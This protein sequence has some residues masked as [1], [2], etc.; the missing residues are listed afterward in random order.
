MKKTFV[1]PLALSLM[2]AG[3]LNMPT[4]PDQITG[5]YV[6]SAKYS[7]FDCNALAAELDSVNRREARAEAA[8]QQRYKSSKQQ[9][10]WYGDGQGDGLEASELANLR[11]ER[12]A[13]RTAISAKG[14]GR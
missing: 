7:S 10:F 1:L 8:Q 2:L 3:C 6:S 12:E 5:S 4:P 11:G 13:L 14:C 9:A